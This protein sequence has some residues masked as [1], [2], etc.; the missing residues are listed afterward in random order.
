M[1]QICPKI[2]GQIRPVNGLRFKK[3]RKEKTHT[4]KKCLS[5]KYQSDLRRQKNIQELLLL[6]HVLRI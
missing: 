2:V 5:T 1:R 6:L 3:K 4:N